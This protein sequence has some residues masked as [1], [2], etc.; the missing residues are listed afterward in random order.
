MG[1]VRHVEPVMYV[2][3]AFSAYPDALD[4]SRDRCQ[5]E[6]GP[7][8]R[9]SPRFAFTET[10][11]YDQDMGQGLNK[12]FWAFAERA[13]PDELP[14]RKLQTNRW[15]LELA[16]LGLYPCHRPLNLDPGYLTTS[17]LVLASTK[18][19]A[20]RLYLGEGIYG[21]ITLRFRHGHWEPWEWTYP[22]YRRGDYHEFFN[23]CR[24]QI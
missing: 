6:W 20:H 23:A 1:N 7:I 3:A 9:E 2:V 10:A 21:E 11:Y 13:S 4:W 5:R 19:H 22:D 24:A 14:L 8:L 15:E 17:K 12:V 16:A 18:D